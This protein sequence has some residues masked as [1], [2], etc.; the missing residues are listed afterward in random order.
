MPHDVS[1]AFYSLAE[2]FE[3]MRRDGP[4]AGDG[5][6]AGAGEGSD[7]LT[8]MIGSLLSQAETPPKE[9]EGA[10]EEFCDSTY[11]P[12]LVGSWYPCQGRSGVG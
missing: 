3:V 5:T 4:G 12:G 2:A 8:Q 7:L 6:G 11:I 9:V 10:S 1:A